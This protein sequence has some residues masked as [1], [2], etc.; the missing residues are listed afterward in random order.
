LEKPLGGNVSGKGWPFTMARNLLFVAVTALYTSCNAPRTLYIG[1]KLEGEITLLIDSTLLK[2]G[3][4]RVV[5]FA[6]SLN[7]RRLKHGHLII[8]FG[9]G[10]WK[11]QD[12]DYLQEVLRRSTVAFDGQ[13]GSFSLPQDIRI[14]HYGAFVNELIFKIKEPKNNKDE[15]Q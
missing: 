8:N 6:D 15:K 7:G 1:N 11:Q 3:A 4:L 2:N 14:T 10:R 9:P 12:K 13:P 5:A